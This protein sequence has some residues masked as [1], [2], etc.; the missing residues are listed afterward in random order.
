[1]ANYLAHTLFINDPRQ[2]IKGHIGSK[3]H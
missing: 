3:L 2:R 1:M